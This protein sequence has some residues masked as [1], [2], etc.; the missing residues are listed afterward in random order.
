M[1]SDDI[2]A[3]MEK[4]NNF[5]TTITKLD[6]PSRLC[7]TIYV[8]DERNFAKTGVEA[9]MQQAKDNLSSYFL[10]GDEKKQESG[11]SSGYR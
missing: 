4:D 8:F 1:K 5:Q 10:D 11:Q 6:N 2:L 3:N 9:A 7:L